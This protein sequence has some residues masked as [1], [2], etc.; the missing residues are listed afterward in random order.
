MRVSPNA[1][2]NKESLLAAAL[3]LFIIKYFLSVSPF[4]SINYPNLNRRDMEVNWVVKK[5]PQKTPFNPKKYAEANPLAPSKAPDETNLISTQNQK[6]AQPI[7]AEPFKNA[8]PLPSNKGSSQNLKIISKAKSQESKNQLLK[9]DIKTSHPQTSMPTPTI[10]STALNMPSNAKTGWQV[11]PKKTH[12]NQKKIHLSDQV[13]V[14]QE[15]EPTT[16]KKKHTHQQKSRP[17]LS[18]ELLN[19][20]LLQK[21][22]STERIGKVAIEC[23][24]NPFGVYM[25]G[26]LKAIEKQWG[27]LILS[28]YRYTQREQYT[29]KATFRFILLS[30]GRIKELNQFGHAHNELLSAELCRQA[31]ASRAPFGQWTQTM[32]EE[33]GESD[34]VSITF[35]YR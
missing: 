8:Q 12:K 14:K 24:L 32:I 2:N 11:E 19:G 3:T 15:N 16:H 1:F 17:R 34:E 20:P 35:N 22:S 26:M 4:A 21:A 9:S 29:G 33:F 6:V 5:L 28:S 27:E 23:R 7:I 10:Q 18:L 13:Q 30:N 31:I 25:Q